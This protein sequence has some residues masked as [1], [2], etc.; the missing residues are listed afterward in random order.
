MDESFI[1]NSSEWMAANFAFAKVAFG[2]L[3]ST[4]FGF[5]SNTY[6]YYLRNSAKVR[7]GGIKRDTKLVIF[8]AI[9]LAILVVV[10]PWK[11]REFLLYGFS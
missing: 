3:I 9:Y 5:Y 11:N 4:R 7:F 10:Y 1:Q 8:G 6:C 2:N